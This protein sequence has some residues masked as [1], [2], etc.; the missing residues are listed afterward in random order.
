MEET[1]LL[2]VSLDYFCDLPRYLS[3]QDGTPRGTNVLLP[4][5]LLLAARLPMGD[6]GGSS[7]EALRCGNLGTYMQDEPDLYTA[8][9]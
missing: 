6:N 9:Q 8:P 2:D 4:R 1:H 7:I 5:E 3:K